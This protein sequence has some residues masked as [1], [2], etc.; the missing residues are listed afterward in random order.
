MKTESSMTIG[1]LAE[2]AAVSIETIRF[3]ERK[4]ILKA[5][6]R[7]SSGYREYKA[8]D[9]IRIRFI[10]RAQELGFTLKEIAQLLSMNV[11]KGA[12]CG[13]M[14]P[15]AQSKLEEIERKIQ[16][17]QIMKESLARFMSVCEAAIESKT[18][19]AACDCRVADCFEE[20]GCA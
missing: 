3:Y 15:K 17:L 6:R 19:R 5:P 8:D 13:Q 14:F 4:G 10:K 2:R 20:G 11:G 18:G 12:S 1:K 7:R 9:A 16:D